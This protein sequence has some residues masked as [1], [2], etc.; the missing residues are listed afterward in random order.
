M[1]ELR[2]P[3]GGSR[4]LPEAGRIRKV[5]AIMHEFE[6]CGRSMRWYEW[7]SGL[8][9]LGLA[10][11][12]RAESVYKCVTAERDVIYQATPCSAQQ[13][14]SR[15]EIPP[16]PVPAPSPRY[17][18]ERHMTDTDA[19]APH[20]RAAVRETASECRVSDGRVFYRLGN[21]PHSIPG[22]PDS[23]TTLHRGR[24]GT[25]RGSGGTA[26]VSSRRIAREEACHEIHRAGAIG[27]N[28]HEFDEHVSSY[29]HNLGRDPC[30]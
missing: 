8:V 24:T 1:R 9:L 16:A 27:R 6:T 22:A 5:E 29:E 4:R 3:I 13:R 17:A 21:C 7:L 10:F 26:Q 20:A 2:C 19:R 15:I 12:V 28:G 25:A 14:A 23:A 30:K 11:G 18:V